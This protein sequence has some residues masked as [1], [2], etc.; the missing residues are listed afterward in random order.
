MTELVREA[1]ER[2]RRFLETLSPDRIAGLSDFVAADVRF[3][4]PFNDVRGCEAMRRVFVHMFE[5]V[6]GVR[7]TVHHVM[8]VGDTCLMHWRFEGILRGAP[9]FFDGTSVVTFDP[10]GKVVAHIDHWDA[11]RAFYERLPLIGWLLRRIRARLA[12][13]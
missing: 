5:N 7:F 9:W 8:T 13:H 6:P 1:A 10:D 2:Y 12:Q 3:V 11:A 4:D